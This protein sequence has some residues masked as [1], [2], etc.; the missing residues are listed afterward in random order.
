LA[1]HARIPFGPKGGCLPLI[2]LNGKCLHRNEHRMFDILEELM[3]R[4]AF[5]DLN[6]LKALLL[7]YRARLESMV[8]PNGHRLAMMLAA[9]NF[10]SA[11]ALDE[12]WHGVHQ[13]GFVK[14]ITED[15]SDAG[16]ERVAASL[17]AIA[18]T[19]L[20]RTGIQ[21][22]IIGEASAVSAAGS[23]V[24]EIWRGLAP[25][26]SGGFR[27]PDIVPD[28]ALPH[29]GWIT[30]V[31]VSYVARV[32]Q[33]VRMDHED[34]PTLLVISKMLRSLF[35]HREIREKG[36]AYGGSARYDGE[37]GLFAFAS[38]RDPHVVATLKV[39][40]RAMVFIRSGGYTD[41]DVKEAILQVC[42]DIDKPDP[43]GP[44]ARKAFYRK[45][46]SL[47]DETRKR[48]KQSVLSTTRSRVKSV[49]ERYFNPDAT[50]HAVAVISGAEKLKAA[51]H[52]APG[53]PLVL[54]RI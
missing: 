32:F 30:P 21:M 24:A 49:A 10:S 5:S 53:S 43:P 51:N 19:L 44:A 47:D 31:A 36:G 1:T 46:I 7:E 2:S 22:A 4:H 29:E 48:F 3:V 11:A 9:R 20:T 35:L 28:P 14:G 12:L 6:R 37:S 45:I 34:S 16:L 54:Y 50:D 27:P 15:L 41:E 8:V 38:Y 40:D 13:L 42:S 17:T 52:Q 25:R 18:K 26:D 33:T 23:P 39:Y